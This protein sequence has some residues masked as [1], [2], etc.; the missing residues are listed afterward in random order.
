[1]I[2]QGQ[3][4]LISNNSFSDGQNYPVLQGK[5]AEMMVAQLH[6]KYYTTCYR[7]NLFMAATGAT[8]TALSTT[9][10]TAQTFGIWNPS[11]SGKLVV[12][13]KTH[14]GYVSGTGVTGAI[15]YGTTPG[16]GSSLGT[17]ISARTALTSNNCNIGNGLNSVALVGSAFTVAAASEPTI[18]RYF[19]FSQGAPAAATAAIHPALIDDWD[20]TVIIPPGNAVFLNCVNQ[21]IVTVF[22]ISIVWEEIP[23]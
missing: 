2:V 3:V 16:V 13:I 15:A 7:G 11:G 21:A 23:L 6:G 1:M 8:G 5:A 12:P 9:A 14:L 19:G 20:Q 22:G 18:F 10:T 17:P 4:N